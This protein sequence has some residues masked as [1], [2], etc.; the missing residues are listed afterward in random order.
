MGSIDIIVLITIFLSIAFALYRGLVSELLSISGWILAALGA[1]YSY[2]PSQSLLKGFISD[3]LFAGVTG[4]F[5]TALLI[6]VVMTLVTAKITHHLRKSPLSGL[7]RTL[8]F[9]F[10]VFRAVLLIAVI[11]LIGN[12]LIFSPEQ[13]KKWE[14]ENKSLPYIQK[15]AEFLEAFVPQSIKDDIGGRL[16]EKEEQKAKEAKGTKKTGDAPKKP[17]TKTPPPKASKTPP[18][19]GNRTADRPAQKNRNGGYSDDNREDLNELIKS[20]ILIEDLN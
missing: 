14:E 3:P 16:K 9:L 8:G 6:L 19:G 11:Y 15:S 7:D 10:G 5:V 17:G 12:A 20:M 4:A 1:L 2:V 13:I 18:K